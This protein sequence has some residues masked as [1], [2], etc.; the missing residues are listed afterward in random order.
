MQFALV[1]VCVDD[2][3]NHELLRIQ[4]RNRLAELYLRC[5][6]VFI[7]NEIGGNMGENFRNTIA[8]IKQS[9]GQIALAAVLHHDD[10]HAAQAGLRRPIVDTVAQM[11]TF[12]AANDIS[13]ILASGQIRTSD[14]LIVWQ[15]EQR[16]KLSQMSQ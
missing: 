5:E 2:R 7:V 16:I 14:N 9:G 8:L 12:L 4:I 3:L 13:C 1:Q 6:H 10:C 15:G 11:A